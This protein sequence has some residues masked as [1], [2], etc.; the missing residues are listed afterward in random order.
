MQCFQRYELGVVFN[1]LVSIIL[2]INLGF[3]KIISLI[4]L[5]ILYFIVF[6]VS[7][8]DVPGFFSVLILSHMEILV[9][10]H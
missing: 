6:S 7:I 1:S 10:R 3:V 5:E 8:I 2:L 4:Y 9:G